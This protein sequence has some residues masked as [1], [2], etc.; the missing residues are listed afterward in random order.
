[1]VT[2]ADRV[3]HPEIKSFEKNSEWYHIVPV[4]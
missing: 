1:M 2:S 4:N 3:R